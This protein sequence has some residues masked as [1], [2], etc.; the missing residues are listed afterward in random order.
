M[1]NILEPTTDILEVILSCFMVLCGLLLFTMLVGNIQ[2]F[3]HA[4]VGR[5]TKT[6]IRLRDMERWM[7]RRQLPSALRKRVRHFENQRWSFLGGQDDME[8]VKDLPEGLRRD[9]KRYLCLALIK[10]ASLF[11]FMDDIILDNI[12]DRVTYSIYSKGEKIIRE[13][14]PV[15][16]IV[17]IVHGKVKRTQWLSRGMVA[18]STL[19][20]GSFFGDELLSWCLRVP[21]IDRFPAATATFTCVKPTEAFALDAKHLRYI[22][23]HFR[24]TFVNEKMKRR[25]RYYSS[26]WRT[27]AAVNIQIAWRRYVSRKLNHGLRDNVR[28]QHYAAMFMSFKPHDHLE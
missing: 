28:L 17:F 16:K 3:L 20:P 12:C 25:A 13:G 26:N 11:K 9:I 22:T 2:V 4:L 27:W 15:E 14:D 18:T 6:Q 23:N 21:Y 24:Y 7:K 19:E 10:K 1:G 5:T 8:M